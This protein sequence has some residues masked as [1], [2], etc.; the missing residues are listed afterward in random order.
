MSEA[1]LDVVFDGPPGP[2]SGRFVDV[3]NESGQSVN[4]GQWIERPDGLWAL[5]EMREVMD[6]LVKSA[7]AIKAANDVLLKVNGRLRR[8]EKRVYDVELMLE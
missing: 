2:I 6:E 4:A 8:L 7:D 5:K 1:F 3:E